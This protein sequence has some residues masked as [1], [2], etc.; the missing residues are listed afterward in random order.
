MHDGSGAAHHACMTGPVR[1]TAVT[2]LSPPPLL[3]IH[4]RAPSG[5]AGQ[6]KSLRS[7]SV[8]TIALRHVLRVP[9][10]DALR[11]PGTGRQRSRLRTWSR[12]RKAYA[13]RLLHACAGTG[14]QS[15]RLRTWSRNARHT[16]A[17]C[18]MHADSDSDGRKGRAEGMHACQ[19]CT[20]GWGIAEESKRLPGTV[21][22]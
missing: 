2:S 22:Q 19:P 3:S 13:C 14:R 10:A 7:G 21:Q 5:P 16:L 1:P 17:S 20:V 6:A 9:V 4:R 8:T 15:R 18:C 12:K 11:P